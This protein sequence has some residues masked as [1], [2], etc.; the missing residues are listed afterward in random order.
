VGDQSTDPALRASFGLPKDRVGI[1]NLIRRLGDRV[2]EPADTW[3]W[4]HMPILQTT[5]CTASIPDMPAE[6]QDD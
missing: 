3:D 1:N 4:L 5:R 6:E 2:Q